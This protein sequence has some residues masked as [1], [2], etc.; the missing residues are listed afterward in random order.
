M[1]HYF[2]YLILLIVVLFTACEEEITIDLPDPEPMVVVEGV[3]ENDKVPYV[4]LTWSS[5]YFDPVDTATIINTIITDAK[6]SVSDGTITESLYAELDT[7]LFPPIAFKAKTMKGEIG[8]EYTLNIEVKGKKYTAK[9]T[10]HQPIPLDSV[11]FKPQPPSDSLGWAW[12]HLSDPANSIDYYRWMT[13]R[14]GKDK[15]FIA[16]LG[17]IFEDRFVNGQSFDF[18]YFRGQTFNSS[19]EDDNNEERGYFKR[20]DTIIVKFSTIDRA[21]FEFFRSFEAESQN[22][23]NPFAAPL[24]IINNIEGGALGAWTGYGAVYDTIYAQ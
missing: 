11:W 8:K 18:A 7:N 10:I 3:I 13:K 2:T 19:A 15:N 16:P 21:N 22:G 12:A 17:S 6:V 14:K 5:P 20:G 4:I 23:G 24:T 1:K 9:T